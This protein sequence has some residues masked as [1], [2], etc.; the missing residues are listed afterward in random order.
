MLSVI[1]LAGAETGSFSAESV[2]RTLAS[3][4]PAVVEGVVRDVTLVA[5]AGV[6]HLRELADHAGCALAEA[7][8]GDFLLA[9]LAAARGDLL[10]IVLAG[11]APDPGFTVEVVDLFDKSSERAPRSALLRAEPDTFP[12]RLV[13]ALCPAEGLIARRG[14][15]SRNISTFADVRRKLIAPVALR[16]R[17]RRVG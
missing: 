3:L 1:V 4:V 10:F 15:L 5:P 14:D 17:L 12:Q 8:A 7:A 13:P 2:A 11:R 6:A 16:C 9:G